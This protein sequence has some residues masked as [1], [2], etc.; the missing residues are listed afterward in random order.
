[1]VLNLTV[2]LCTLLNEDI[3]SR[4][5]CIILFN[6]VTSSNCSWL[7]PLLPSNLIST[8]PTVWPGFSA[9]FAWDIRQPTFP[10]HYPLRKFVYLHL[11]SQLRNFLVFSILW[12]WHPKC[13]STASNIPKFFPSLMHFLSLTSTFIPLS[14]CIK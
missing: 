13:C 10:A 1:M 14:F 2:I 4:S 9:L 11:T 5:N 3:L 7:N 12:T 8:F 6:L